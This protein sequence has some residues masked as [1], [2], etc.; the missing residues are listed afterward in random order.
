MSEFRLASPFSDHMVLQRDAP[1]PIWGLDRP[2]TRLA[3]SSG[4]QSWH[5]LADDGG[6][7]KVDIGPFPVGTPF[8]IDIQGTEHR[9]LEDVLAGEVWLASGQSNMEW[10]LSAAAG[11]MEVVGD[12]T[13]PE[14]RLLTIPRNGTAEPVEFVENSGWQRCTPESAA[15]FSAVGYHFGRELHQELGVPVGLI[16]NAWGGATMESYTRLDLLAEDPM[17]S[18]ES[19]RI[20]KEY[21]RMRSAPGVMDA[22][23]AAMKRWSDE[24]G[25]K[26][27]HSDPGDDG[28]ARGWADKDCDDASW[29]VARIP[30][31]IVPKL[32][33]IDGAFWF[34]RSIELPEAWAG[35]EL[36][37]T[38]G[39]MDSADV[40]YVNGTEVGRTGSETPGYWALKR[41]YVIPAGT[42][43]PGR[44]VV[45]LRVFE[46]SWNGETF[47]QPR[48]DGPRTA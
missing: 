5:A 22:F 25:G 7:W 44:N 24:T 38:L 1:V 47:H 39:I 40:A 17:L 23:K 8:R 16:C 43:E 41:A 33:E 15:P 46:Q 26:G 35:K 31:A 18:A 21:Q 30:E 36:V 3:I 4:G 14:I 6:R 32:G 13:W 2:G 9:A 37:L 27:Y 28:V 10:P 48:A 11:G 20:Y 34:R 12:A 42:M 19:L 45:T 29:D